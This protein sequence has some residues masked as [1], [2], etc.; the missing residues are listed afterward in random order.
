MTLTPISCCP[1]ASVPV[2]AFV[3]RDYL[4][5]ARVLNAEMSKKL[6]SKDW[7]SFQVTFQVERNYDFFHILTGR[8]LFPKKL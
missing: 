4:P 7:L 3:E 8:F 1:A 5:S 2:E 6:L